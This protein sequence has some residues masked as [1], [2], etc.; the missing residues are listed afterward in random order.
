MRH[1]LVDGSNVVRR[2]NYDPRFPEVEERRTIDFL[3]R[4]ND[5]AGS[6]GGKI[7]IEIFFDGHPRPLM[8]VAPPVFIRFPIDGYADAAILGSARGLLVKGRGVIVV[9]GDGRLAQELGEEGARVIRLAE[10]EARLRE[11]RA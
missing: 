1:Y 9:T 3:A 2:G 4:I 6:C 8:P 11:D 10:L 5:L 7:R